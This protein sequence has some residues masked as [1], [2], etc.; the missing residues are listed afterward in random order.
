MFFVMWNQIKTV[1]LLGV[2]SGLVLGIGYLLGGNSGLI[3]GLVFAVLLNFGMFFWSHKLVLAMYR[4][5]PALKKDYPHLHKMVEELAKKAG[6]PK[7]AVYI[8]PTET[9]NAFATGPTYKKAVVACTEGI[10]KLLDDN[11]LKGVLAHEL[12]HIKNRDM[13]VATLAA[14]LAAVLSTVS[15]IALFTGMGNSR[16]RGIHP[17]AFILMV[18]VT[19]II[20][21][22]IQ[23]A[24]SRSRE[25]L[26]DES[27]AKLV[28]A[29]HPLAS[30]LH[31]LENGCHAAPLRFGNPST[32]SMFIVNPFTAKGFIA[33][34]STHPPTKSRIDRLSRMRF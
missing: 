14:T 11:E 4:A 34:F 6:I 26:A 31:K 30:A 18:I 12:S 13:L 10:M 15:R 33:L 7:P 22:L 20:A 17:I 28:G 21:L 2:L 23:F 8:I 1:L 3:I 29:G 24:I 5:K 9:P 19:P 32:S 16:E 25:Y 27:G